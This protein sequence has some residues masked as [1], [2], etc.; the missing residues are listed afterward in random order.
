MFLPGFF[1]LLRH[2]PDERLDRLLPTPLRQPLTAR[3]CD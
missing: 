3:S 1:A 2:A